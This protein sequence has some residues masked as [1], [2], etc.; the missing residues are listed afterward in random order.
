M[1]RH[2]RFVWHSMLFLLIGLAVLFPVDGTAHISPQHYPAIQQDGCVALAPQS[3]A[4][5]DLVAAT[6]NPDPRFNVRGEISLGQKE[7]HFATIRRSNGNLGEFSG[8]FGF[9]V[10]S[11]FGNTENIPEIILRSIGGI[12]SDWT[13]YTGTADSSTT[14]V[15]DGD[16][17]L[18][19]I[20]VGNAQLFALTSRAEEDW[21]LCND[22]L[23]NIAAGA[24]RLALWW[25]EGRTG[26]L[27]I[28]NDQDPQVIINWYYA[29]SAY[30]GGPARPSDDYPDGLWTNNPNC[31][32]EPDSYCDTRPNDPR[33]DD[34]IPDY[35]NSRN[36]QAELWNWR[37]LQAFDYPYQERVLYNIEAQKQP[38]PQNAGDLWE[39]INI[40]M[41]VVSSRRN[42]GRRPAD[43]LFEENGV[44]RAP[45]LLLFRTNTGFLDTTNEPPELII[46]YDLPTTAEVTITLVDA[47]D[48]D[49]ETLLSEQ[50]RQPV[51]GLN[52]ER[53]MPS[54]VLRPDYGYR[55]RVKA[56][57]GALAAEGE[58][59][60]PIITAADDSIAYL[61][62]V[63]A[64]TS[65][66]R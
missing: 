63:Q 24:T 23:A 18:M 31:A 45:N 43:T 65:V 15:N 20:N 17:G 39:S 37:T 22:T 6:N 57:E 58:Y 35:T 4:Q 51:D 49:L 11:Q 3:P 46:E 29:L 30:N 41:N 10:I 60:R 40:G 13:Q 47:N 48:E 32:G 38:S 55:I 33:N 1:G 2:P 34:I 19:Q 9:A 56:G 64:N 59:I 14:L 53:L 25:E 8:A 27:P 52:R 16:F 50:Q 62:L 61:P 54:R 5:P 66:T 12:E 26:D 42:Y 44:S 36:P 28:V 21:N 7:E